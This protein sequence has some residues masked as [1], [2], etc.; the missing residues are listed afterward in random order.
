MTFTERCEQCN[1]T[2]IDI[3]FLDEDPD[4]PCSACHGTGRKLTDEARTLIWGATT[5]L[6]ERID[7]L[8]QQTAFLN[9]ELTKLRNETNERIEALDSV[10]F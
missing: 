3:P 5:R 10:P 2:G 7:D 1:G 8:E 4:Y 9:D 6:R